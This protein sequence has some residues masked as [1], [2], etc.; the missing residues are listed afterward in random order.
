MNSIKVYISVCMLHRIGL[1]NLLPLLIKLFYLLAGKVIAGS[2][3]LKQKSG[4]FFFSEIMC[5]C[6]GCRFR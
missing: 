2:S 1:S 4:V 3:R 5:C 6:L